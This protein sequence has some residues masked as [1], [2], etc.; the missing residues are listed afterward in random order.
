MKKIILLLLL[1]SVQY[2]VAAQSNTYKSASV[3]SSEK[4]AYS[5]G[6]SQS[7]NV[8]TSNS[9]SNYNAQNPAPNYNQ[10]SVKNNSNHYISNYQYNTSGRS[11]QIKIISEEPTAVTIPVISDN[12]PVIK[13]IIPH[14][15]KPISKAVARNSNVLF[16]TLADSGNVIIGKP[17]SPVMINV[18]DLKKGSTTNVQAKYVDPQNKPFRYRCIYGNI[19][20]FS[21][22]E[23][24][25]V[26]TGSFK[27]LNY[28]KSIMLWL[29][30]KYKAVGYIFD[31]YSGGLHYYLVLGKYRQY[32]VAEILEG[33]VRTEFT[34]A[35]VVRWSRYYTSFFI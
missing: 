29:T 21:N 25:G 8:N 17:I 2:F 32:K 3:Y 6:S 20:D 26:Y 16:S 4:V 14:T 27:N 28:C 12:Y 10:N 24:Y 18:V 5:S 22:T 1:F 33:K 35:F 19:Y 11:K 7:V 23:G 34:K 15:G 13:S 31:D 9:G 30:R